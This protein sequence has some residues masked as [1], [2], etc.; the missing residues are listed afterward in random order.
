MIS[1]KDLSIRQVLKVLNGYHNNTNTITKLLS[2]VNVD[3]AGQQVTMPLEAPDSAPAI[4]RDAV[5][6]DQV[7]NYPTWVELGVYNKLKVI[8][9]NNPKVWS[10]LQELGFSLNDQT[11]EVIVAADVENPIIEC[12]GEKLEIPPHSRL[13]ITYKTDTGIEILER[14]FSNNTDSTQ[15]ITVPKQSIQLPDGAKAVTHNV[16]ISNM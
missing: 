13:T 11:R 12:G 16:V 2:Y 5:Y 4:L 9:Q 14:Q 1:K 3:I 10:K 6:T 15:S 7:N 8:S